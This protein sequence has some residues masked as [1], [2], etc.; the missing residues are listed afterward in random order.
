M[1][2]GERVVDGRVPGYL[3][4]VL[5]D[6][7][8]PVGT[9]FQVVPGVLVT[10]WHVL[11]DVGATGEGAQVGV[12]PLAGGEPFSAVVARTDPLR[13][14][15]VLT[16]G[17][18]LSGVAGPL[19]ATDQV[20]R[21]V[22]VTVTGHAVLDDPGRSYLFLDA[23]GEWAGGTTRGDSVPLGRMTSSSVVPGMSGAP[24]IRDSD[25]TV[26]GVV[27]GRYNSADGWLVGTVWVARTEDLAVLLD[28]IADVPVMRPPLEGAADLLLEV[29]EDRVRLTGPGI[30]VTAAH[31]G[32]RPGLAEAVHEVR[33]ERDQAELPARPGAEALAPAGGMPL[34][35]AGRLLGESFL[36]GPV[37]EELSRVLGAAGRAHQ[38]VR[39]G[40]AVP[41]ELAGLPWEA[42]PGPDGRPLVLHPLVSMYRKADAAPPRALPGPLRVVVAIACPDAGGGLLLDYEREL[43]NVLAEVRTARQDAADVRVVPF[44]T[45]GAIRAELDRGPAHVLHVSAHGSP[46]LL[47]LED[48][49]GMA[50]PVTADEL[51]DL[52]IPP[53]RMPPVVTLSACHTDTASQDGASFAARLCQHG[54][55]AVI[56]TEASITDAYATRLLARVYG[57]L[58]QA[59]NPDVV[60]ALAEARRQVQAELEASPRLRDRLLAGL[61]EWAAVTVLAVSGS[62]PV[63]DAG[64]ATSAVRR[65]S[66]PRIAGLG[67]RDDWYFVGRRAEQR[68][69]PAE[70]T[71]PG[72]AGIVVCGIGGTG[73]TTLAAEVISRVRDR[74]PARVLVS[75]VGPLP[76]EALLGAVVTTI[77]R[78]L[79]VSG[80]PDAA[81]ALRALDVAA[82]ADAGWQDRLAI[83]R[84]HVLDHVPVLVLLD[85][86]E[87]NLGPGTGAD[88]G[89]VIPDEALAGLLAAWL[90]DPGLSRLLITSRYPFIM[91]GD[92]QRFLSFR[93]LGAL[94][95]AET[96]KLAWSLPALDKLDEGELERAWQLVGGHPRSLEYL[97]ALLAGGT[98]RY[99][100]VTARLDAAVSRRLGGDSRG[101][102]LA[103]RTEVDAALAE[104]VVLAADDV[105]LDDLLARLARVSG[106]T[107]LLLGVSVYREPVDLTAV[108][109]Q[110]GQPDPNAEDAPGRATASKR[111]AEI[112]AAAGITAVDRFDLT[113][114]PKQLR[115][116][117]APHIK[118]LNRKPVPPFRPPANLAGLIAACQAASLLTVN[119]EGLE[120]QFF[121]HRWTATELAGR[122]SH[123]Q[124]P[125]LEQAHRQAA[126][127][128]Q[129]RA[130]AWPQ[131]RAASVHDL[132]EA[133][134]HLLHTGSIEDT[135]QVTLEICTQLHTWG[136]WDQEASLV[137]DTLA[138]LAAD[139]PWQ[140]V[141]IHRLGILAQERGEYDEAARHYQRSLGIFERLGNRAN[142]AT[143]YNNLGVIAQERGDYNE[144]AR[145]YR[146]SLAIRKQL[147]D[148]SGMADTHHNLGN[149]AYL[150]G[151]YDKAARQYQRSLDIKERIGDHAGMASTYGQLGVL[152]TNQGDYDEAARQ[153]QRSLAIRERL[154]DQSGMADTHHK[155]GNLAYLRGQYDEAARHYQRSLDFKERLGDQSGMA[156]TY[157]EL[158]SLAR[159]RGDYDEAARQYQRSLD[160]FERLGGQS[161]MASTYGQF[162][163][164]A[165]LRGQYD[166]A[167]R[168]YQRS[169]DTFERL[170]D[171][172]G[173]ASTYAHLGNLAYAQGDYDEA[174]RQYQSSLEISERL[175]D[176]SGVAG[177]YGRLAVLAQARGDYEEATR[178]YQRS[179]DTFER[180]GN[181]PGMANAYHNLGSLAQARGDY[182]EAARQYRRSLAIN[183]RL[184]NEADVAFSRTQLGFLAQ[185]RGDYDEAARQYEHSLSTF[186]RLGEQARMAGSYGQLGNLACLRGDY[187]EAARLYQRSLDTFERLGN[188][189]G[190]AVSYAQLGNL[191]QERGDYDEAARL[192][193]RSLAISERLG[194]QA[195]MG[196]NY[197]NL[198]VLAQA[199]GDY[200]EAARLYRRS[201]AI[202]ERLGNQV[203]MA[204]TYSQLGVLEAE[205]GGSAQLVIGWHVKA[206]AIRDRLGVPQAADDL[207]RLAAQ[208]S[209]LGPQQFASL[210]TQAASDTSLSILTHLDRMEATDGS[211]T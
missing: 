124:H 120:P 23:P 145:Q 17:A 165:Y 7:S 37:R 195:Q 106:A 163:L 104:A 130:R 34:G 49:D 9:C 96:M 206:L 125:E 211:G 191:A 153:C 101:R 148:Q 63:V 199:C 94:S 72:T 121:V 169:L 38:P 198:G 24:V 128:W 205:Q 10:A 66:R 184:G 132:I 105:L 167:A 189:A 69:W 131:D 62:A 172:S 154:G 22:L 52:A 192:Y 135:G 156:S 102:W 177:S 1:T 185:E 143:S 173:M 20:P 190:V 123:E 158:G 157:Y 114:A 57:A 168:H 117:L 45:P 89:Y 46:G 118:E 68:L 108:L 15:A 36:P 129:W 41:P 81:Q 40:L 119:V 11:D 18:G 67:G 54:A 12:G 13:D 182:D 16:C 170:G 138:H 175:G 4:R 91:P 35:R 144:A 197:H 150:H 210:L 142:M 152:A 82:R 90:A 50:R 88:A 180:L 61:G 137:Q 134:H 60:A 14:L 56:A 201:L 139:S 147:G 200:D 28:R 19:T 55:A 194:D 53:G 161:G 99:P 162:G 6:D 86:F 75:L 178:Q 83:L 176:Q 151:Q 21:R 47:Y 51:A 85:N 30:D 33:R 84:G 207:R 140:A 74:E 141:W 31:D 187:D 146:R 100:D 155:L 32:V 116:L 70:L 122:A 39:I 174:A 98:A 2:A 97:D 160:I 43:R 115:V 87:D 48:E 103:A 186:E 93:Q 209:E 64:Q 92:A 183:E 29:T 159:T 5:D 44:A 188:Q 58:A 78:E 71:G 107:E 26:A 79:L 111:I 171:Q 112:L 77:R 202:K 8:V 126:R 113:S 204:T 25:G 196:I 181:Q 109:F 76:L 203:G 42:L 3:G 80:G 166:E 65:P 133:R 179:L 208:R 193:Q 127:Y 164:L 27:S 110:A 149:L 59:A 73:K 95:R 136:A